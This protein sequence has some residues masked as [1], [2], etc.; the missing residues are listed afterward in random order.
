MRGRVRRFLV[1]RVLL[2][3]HAHAGTE[4]RRQRQLRGRRLRMHAGLV[5]FAFAC[6]MVDCGGLLGGRLGKDMNIH[7]AALKKSKVCLFPA[8]AAHALHYVK[9]M[10]EPVRVQVG[11]CP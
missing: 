8:A 11:P 7:A 5:F 4:R 10:I 9:S 2:V 3:E 6:N 1:P